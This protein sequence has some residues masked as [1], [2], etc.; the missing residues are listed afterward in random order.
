[1]ASVTTGVGIFETGQTIATWDRYARDVYFCLLVTVIEREPFPRWYCHR[2]WITCQIFRWVFA[3]LRLWVLPLQQQWKPQETRG[4]FR[5]I[6]WSEVRFEFFAIFE[7]EKNRVFYMIFLVY[8][9]RYY[10]NEVLS[11]CFFYQDVEKN[12]GCDP[13]PC[14]TTDTSQRRIV[15]P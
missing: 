15:W 8:Y 14:W 3:D 13:E 9:P 5:W 10:L 4:F 12:S 11:T 2:M 6:F 7:P 1:M